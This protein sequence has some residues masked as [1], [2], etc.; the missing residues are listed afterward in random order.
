MLSTLA[1]S[2]PIGNLGEAISQEYFR[3]RHYEVGDIL[4]V[5]DQ[6]KFGYDFKVSKNGISIP[7]ESKLDDR[8]AETGFLF[9]EVRT[10]HQRGWTQRYNDDS[11]V[12]I[13][14]VFPDSQE[15]WFFPAKKL[16]SIH[17][18]DFPIKYSRNLAFTCI[19]HQVPMG[20][21]RNQCKVK[22]Y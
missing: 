13:C 9:W 21:I 10:G 7:I 11:K 19:G 5:A 17:H 20:F 4:S 16:K 2:A 15:L 18:E 12:Q 14:W 1:K 6:R 3:Q 8:A 22:N